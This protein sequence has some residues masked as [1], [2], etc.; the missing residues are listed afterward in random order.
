MSNDEPRD[1][2]AAFRADRS[3]PSGAADRSWSRLTERIAAGEPAPSLADAPVPA[4]TRTRTWAF[5]LAAAAVALIAARLLLPDSGLFRRPD[6]ASEAPYQRTTEVDAREVEPRSAPAIRTTPWKPVSEASPAPVLAPEPPPA[7]AVRRPAPSSMP[8]GTSE[9]DLA[10]QLELVRAAA[11]AV[12]EGDGAGA[13]QQ[14]D[15]YLSQYPRGAFV[16]EARLARVEALCRLARPADAARDV[17]AFVAAYPES[18]LRARVESA[19]PADRD[20]G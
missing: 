5:V 14:A 9:P 8:S 19:C 12:R 13:L 11:R 7:P 4:D 17:A 10:R 16:P 6:A 1:L 2:L 20:D 3:P 15:D 18:P